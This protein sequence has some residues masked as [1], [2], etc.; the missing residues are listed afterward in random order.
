MGANKPAKRLPSRDRARG[1][2]QV[3]A[4]CYRIRKRGIEFLLVQ[5]RGGRWIFPKGGV[6]PGLTRA[7]SAALEAFEEAGVHGR[8]ETT[9]FARYF[10]REGDAITNH[11]KAARR[12]A[13]QAMPSGPAITA[14]L[15]EVSRLEKSQELN[16]Y[17]T[18]FTTE[19]AK[20]CLLQDREPEFGVELAAVVDRAAAR[21]RRLHGHPGATPEHKRR[22]PLHEVHFEAREGHFS[23]LRH[24]LESST[25]LRVA[26]QPQVKK[27]RGIQASISAIPRATFDFERPLLQLGAGTTSE[28]DS[29]HNVTAIDTGRV[30]RRQTTSTPS[31]SKGRFFA[32]A[33]RRKVKT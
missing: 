11:Q 20:Q 8:I 12:A 14:H 19:K 27:V 9:P 7:Q 26:E 21:I 4:V 16:R 33:K 29:L 30:T 15:C 32:K 28:S 24:K 25:F 23:Q 10:R 13:S 17:P 6:E 18:W 5:T 2:Q 3:A 22:E 31:G 1:R